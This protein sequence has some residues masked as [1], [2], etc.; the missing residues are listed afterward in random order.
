M[1]RGILTTNRRGFHKR[2]EEVMPAQSVKV[3][4]AA[5]PEMSVSLHGICI[6]KRKPLVHAHTRSLIIRRVQLE[7]AALRPV[8]G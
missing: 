2:R 6:H 7:C 3:G 1:I 5:R 8:A 4:H